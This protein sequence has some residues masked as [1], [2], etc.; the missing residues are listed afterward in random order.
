MHDEENEIVKL[1]FG[2]KGILPT[3]LGTLHIKYEGEISDRELKGIYVNRWN[4]DEREL[5][6]KLWIMTKLDG[7][8]A[9]LALPC[10]DEPEFKAIFKLELEIP[11]DLDALFNTIRE[12]EEKGR[13]AG[14]KRIIFRETP[15]MSTSSLAF[16]IGKFDRAFE[17]NV[18]GVKIR[19]VVPKSTDDVKRRKQWA[20]WSLDT[21]ARLFDHFNK[22]YGR[23][24]A[25][26]PLEK[27]D[28]IVVPNYAVR[29]TGHFGHIGIREDR[30]WVNE[31]S[32]PFTKK[33]RVALELAK[34]IARQ[35]IG[36]MVSIKERKRKFKF[37]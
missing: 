35:W 34:Q 17:K 31:D 1:F 2:Q 23:D 8:Q 20:N 36:N 24:K 13:D 9:R 30:F 3:G 16:T 10:W 7:C 21:G 32:S 5:M 25:R 28:L 6:D 26:Y 12:K 14:W 4:E 15:L 37:N 27:L 29:G 33:Q 11:N 18:D 19:V 22:T